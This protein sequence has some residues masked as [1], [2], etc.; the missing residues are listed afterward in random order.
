MSESTTHSEAA[1]EDKLSSEDMRV[2]VVESALRRVECLWQQTE[3]RIECLCQPYDQTSCPQAPAAAMEPIWANVTEAAQTIRIRQPRAERE[4]EA[5][6]ARDD[7]AVSGGSLN[8]TRGADCSVL[9]CVQVTEPESGAAS[10]SGEPRAKLPRKSAVVAR[11]CIRRCADTEVMVPD[12][13]A[14]FGSCWIA[15]I[16]LLRACVHGFWERL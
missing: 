16:H 5:M 12:E 7:D 4:E 3:R 10:H 14:L 15:H 1:V 11:D 8:Q 6:T 9:A 13:E 2:D